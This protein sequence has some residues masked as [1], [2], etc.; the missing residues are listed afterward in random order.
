VTFWRKFLA[1]YLRTDDEQKITDVENKARIIGYTRLLRRN[2]RRGSLA[3][4]AGRAE[5]R[6]WRGELLSL[7]KICDTLLFTADDG[8]D[9]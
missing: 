9:Q 6:L 5:L 7:L 1:A 4:E 8:K 2:I 3:T